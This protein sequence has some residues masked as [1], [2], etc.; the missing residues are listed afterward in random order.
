MTEFEQESGQFSDNMAGTENDLNHVLS[1][2]VDSEHAIRNFCH[3]RYIG[4]SEIQSIFQ[5][6]YREFLILTL[7]IQSVNAKFKNL[8]PVI[9]NLTS[10]GLYFGA[11]CFQETWTSN[12]SDLSLLQLPGYQP[13][14]QGS[15]CTKHRGLII[16]L[17]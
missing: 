1:T 15:K 5:N 7:N 4:M 6:N 11:T 8:Y 13:I 14:H 17:K 12:D 3:L 2:F 10:Q 9:N 16:Y